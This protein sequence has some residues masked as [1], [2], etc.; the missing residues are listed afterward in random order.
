MAEKCDHC[1]AIHGPGN[2]N[3][4]CPLASDYRPFKDAVVLVEEPAQPDTTSFV[5]GVNAAA[6][7][8][9][10][11]NRI[12]T[13]VVQFGDDWPGVFIRGDDCHNFLLHLGTA[14]ETP[15]LDELTVLVLKGLE[16][17]LAS[18]NVHA[19]PSNVQHLLPYK[20]CAKP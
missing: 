11:Q 12:E 6:E 2:T 18:S 9:R 5:V 17:T 1:E 14:L 3:T 19:S 7:A 20:D 8:M 4:M 15:G 16:S 10:Q 13:G